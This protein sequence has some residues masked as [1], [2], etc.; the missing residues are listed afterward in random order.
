MLINWDQDRAVKVTPALEFTLELKHKSADLGN[1]GCVQTMYVHIFSSIG[2]DKSIN[3][4]PIFT[5]TK[6]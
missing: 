1:A 4:N 6:M 2:A 5:G 3:I